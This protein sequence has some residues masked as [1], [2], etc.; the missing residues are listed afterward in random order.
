MPLLF[1]WICARVCVCIP[2]PVKRDKSE[3]GIVYGIENCFQGSRR[4]LL[5][6]DWYYRLSRHLLENPFRICC[7]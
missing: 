7:G 4:V 6:M 5:E 2:V 1:A 3:K